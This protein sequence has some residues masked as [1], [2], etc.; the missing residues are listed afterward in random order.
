MKIKNLLI[1]L[2][3]TS[4]GLV[5]QA[6]AQD[7]NP[8]SRF[9]GVWEGDQGVDVSPAQKKTRAPGSAAVS[10]FFERI[11]ILAG[12]AA[13]NASEQDL[14]ALTVRQQVFRKSDQQQFHDQLGYLI[15]DKKNAKVIYS[16]CVPRGVCV[17]AEGE[18]NKKDEFSA[19]TKTAFAETE[20]MRKNA[21]TEGFS[22]GMN[23]NPDNTLS[24]SQITA[25]NI[26]GNKF[27]HAD[28]N[29]L[30]KVADKPAQ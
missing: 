13:T 28:S 14:E 30:R 5:T 25:L 17:S 27:S 11:E 19:S 26:Y 3:V 22:I 24:Y 8:L 18:L 12:P 29:V 15:W 7:V 21:K 23:I 2:T 10:P 9:I 6:H 16:F 20:F 1:V 4:A